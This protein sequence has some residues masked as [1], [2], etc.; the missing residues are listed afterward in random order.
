MIEN[1]QSICVNT[2]YACAAGVGMVVAAYGVARGM[3]FLSGGV[4]CLAAASL[5]GTLIIGGMTVTSV[6][7]A[8]AKT[9]DT[10]QVGGDL[11]STN[12][13]G[14]VE[15]GTN[16]VTQ[17]EVS[18]NDWTNAEGT[19]TVGH[20]D[21]ER[22]NGT[23]AVTGPL[24]LG[25]P[26]RP[27]L[28]QMLAA[29]TDADIAAG[30]REVSRSDAVLAP[31]VFAKPDD[32]VVWETARA[33]GVRRGF[34]KI[35]FGGW[36]FPG[37]GTSW[38]NGFV[39]AEGMFRPRVDSKRDGFALLD[40]A[41]ALAPAANWSRYGLDASL[42][43]CHTNAVGGLVGT[44]L[45]A[46]VDDDPAKIVNAQ[47]ELFPSDGRIAL[48]YDLA[49]A[50]E[51][52]FSAGPFENGTN[53]FAVVSSN[54]AEIVFQRVHP[55]DWDMD[56]IP[57]GM[58]DDPRVAA[59]NAG[60]NQ[61]DAWA[62]L[63]F[64]S[65]AAEI[66]A[67]GYAAWAAARAVDPNRRLVGLR[68][69]SASGAWPLLLTFGDVQVMCDGKQEIVFAIDCGAKYAYSVNGGRLDRVTVYDGQDR[70][71]HCEDDANS[72]YDWFYPRYC[73][74]GWPCDVDVHLESSGTGYMMSAP[75]VRIVEDVTHLFP[76]EGETISAVVT[77]CHGDAYIGCTWIGGDGISFSDEH[78]L[79]TTINWNGLDSVVW[80]TN[81]VALV[82]TYEGGYAVTNSH[83]IGV[84]GQSTPTTTFS[85]SCSPVQFL[86]DGIGGD[87]PE[88]V[89][90]LSL[91]LLA[92]HGEG[93]PVTLTCDGPTGTRF[94]H[95]A[96]RTAPITE[97]NPLWISTPMF[98]G[99]GDDATAY[100]TSTNLGRATVRAV[101]SGDGMSFVT[102][103][104]FQVI[105][106]IRK[107][108][109][110]NK[111][112]ETSMIMNPCRLV[113][114]TNAVLTVGVKLA[115]GD[116]F[117][118]TNVVWN[119]V[120]GAVHKV[121]EVAYGNNWYVTVESTDSAG[122][123]DSEAV[124]E[125]KFNDDPIQPRFVLP[126]VDE[127]VIR[128][129]AFV[130]QPPNDSS[131]Y[132]WDKDRIR[133]LFSKAN[134]VFLQAGVRFSLEE[135]RTQ[136][137][138]T[139]VDW[140]LTPL[141][142][143]R[144]P[145]GELAARYSDQVVR[146]LDVHPTNDCIKVFFT[147][148]IVGIRAS[149]FTIKPS[150]PLQGIFVGT[151][152]SD[153]TLAHELGHAL[154]LEDC[155]SSISI[156]TDIGELDFRLD[157]YGATVDSTVF[158]DGRCDWMAETGRGFY[159]KTDKVGEV[160]NLLLMQRDYGTDKLDLPDGKVIGLTPTA[161]DSSSVHAPEVGARYFM[162]SDREVYTHE[163]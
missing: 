108:V 107:L 92:G 63:A 44:F 4:R 117:D 89:Y 153:Y 73:S 41:L 93:G 109:N 60:W 12:D 96:E 45:G 47:F 3:K 139:S 124:I 147:G 126:I 116:T 21:G 77:N 148:S 131:L 67:M 158:P 99:F 144:K 149:A 97:D 7:V 151:A 75:E 29:I 138:G 118:A 31:S 48:R 127:R 68:V 53:H 91:D 121:S 101:L 85:A 115:D 78:S 113:R 32:A 150:I 102:N 125:A 129:R 23:G 119:V 137:V 17:T 5:A 74:F 69:S 162:K 70:V 154:G 84:G 136:G 133:E 33:R 49:R 72:V 79:T 86:N 24:M 141:T 14:Q 87:R 51:G 66:A 28:R 81:H 157:N 22:M 142:Y 160:L 65:N 20:A 13:V 38:S 82:T 114:G 55:D 19:N 35:P 135:I 54:T 145:T 111:Y 159:E 140:N 143:Y 59:T 61:S 40:H 134:E 83:Y 36:D 6:R 155:I 26:G 122:T 120:S 37:C 15:G 94:Y 132:G 8:G 30:W 161:T 34:W 90:R 25:L 130:I 80:T 16:T 27:N 10:Q 2:A 152:A 112:D 56:G 57:N 1:I 62:I 146:L 95:D 71:I 39:W 76:N 106:P 64:P 46:A 18:T 88:R 104:P 156:R 128:V 50:G 98:G 43:W 163:K 58:D 42:F 100:M 11:S 105:E 9:N 103:L 52:P 110:T 123:A